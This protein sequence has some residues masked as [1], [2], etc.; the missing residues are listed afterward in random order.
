MRQV[1]SLDSGWRF[2]LGDPTTPVPTD[3]HIAAYMANK[4]GWSRGPAKGNFDDSDWRVVDLPHDWSVEGPIDR[5]NY[6]DNGFLPR[7]VGWYRRHFQLEESDR[8]KYLALQFDGVATHCTV[9]VNGHLLHRNFCGYTPFTIDIS[10]VANFGEQQ[11]NVIAVFVDA[12]SIEGWWYEGA[13]IYRHTWLIKSN[14]IHVAHNSL[15]ISADPIEDGSW[16]TD[17]DLYL[18]NSSFEDR[19][20]DIEFEVLDADG[21]TIGT[22]AESDNLVPRRN[23]SYSVEHIDV[24]SPRLWTIEKPNLY[25][26]RITVR[27]AGQV[28]DQVIA[29]YGYRSIRFDPDQGFFLNDQPM[30]LLGTCIHQDHAGVGVAVPDSI[31]AFRIRRLKE[32]GCNAIRT[33]HHPPAPELLDACDRLGMLVIDENRNFGSSPQHFEQLRAMVERDRNHP[34][35]IAWSLSNEEA[36]QGTSAAHRITKSMQAYVKEELDPTRPVT[37]A[38]SGGILNDDSQADAIEVMGINYQLPLHDAYHAKHSTTPLIAA[39]THCTLATRGVYKT[40]PDKFHFAAYDTDTVPWGATARQTWRE[41]ASRRFIAGLFIWTGFDY[42]GE[43][44]PH[45]WPCVNSH[46]GLM[47]TCGFAKDSFHLHKVYFTGRSGEPFVHLL[48]HWNWPT[49]GEP[50]RVMTYAN[51]DEAELFLNGQSLGRKPVDPIEM[52]EWNVPYQRGQLKAIG[53]REGRAVAEAIAETTGPAAALGLE[54][55][56]SFDARD[57]RPSDH[58]FRARRSC[59]A[60][61]RCQPSR[62]VRHRWSGEDHRRRQWRSDLP[63][64]RQGVGPKPLPR[65]GTG[66]RADDDVRRI[67]PAHRLVAQSAIRDTRIRIDFFLS[68]PRDRAGDGS[69]FHR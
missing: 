45:G 61:A 46:F 3:K 34:C 29:S 4:A 25:R 26:L 53:Y 63:R 62:R 44:S 6:L 60:R 5:K 27:M 56:P 22:A 59:P 17:V 33:A 47:D 64:S 52:A 38:V 2:Q 31:Q 40:D 13:G 15:W 42:R 65:A 7:G 1:L 36:I 43:P 57:F 16:R 48:P 54:I 11:L 10:D 32:M 69:T 30:R 37:A 8:G 55:H 35:V 49:A 18:E 39:E 28:I 23:R 41:I 19:K 24:R 68:S 51:C 14:L 9:Y 21:A 20:V 58:C 66:D 12:T 67:D 50:I